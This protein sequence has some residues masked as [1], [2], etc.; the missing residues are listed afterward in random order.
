MAKSKMDANVEPSD[1]LG[2]KSPVTSLILYGAC[3]T[4]ATSPAVPN[5]FRTIPA[6]VPCDPLQHLWIMRWYR[7]CLLEGRSPFFCPEVQ[8]PV[9]APLGNFSPMHLQTLLFVPISALTGSD[10]Y[11]YNLI[12][13][14]GLLSTAMGTYL[15]VWAVLRQTTC[16]FFGG[17]ATMLC[18]PM[19]AHAAT[20][21]TELLYLG[22]FPLAMIAW[23]RF[24]DRPG[25]RRLACAVGAV[26]LM[27]MGAAYYVVMATIPMSLYVIWRARCAGLA[28]LGAWVRD[29]AGWWLGFGALSVALLAILFSAS[30]WASAHGHAMSRSKEE[31]NSYGASPW[32]Y[33]VPTPGHRLG[34]CLPFD[35]ATIEG[36][37]YSPVVGFFAMEKVSYLGAVSLALVAYAALRRVRFPDAGFWWTALGVSV[38]LSLGSKGRVG[39]FEVELP[40][41]WLYDHVPIFRLTR[42]PSRFNLFAAVFAAVV[43]SAGLKDLLGRLP[44]RMAPVVMAVLTVI[45]VADLSVPLGASQLPTLPQGY[46]AILARDPAATFYEISTDGGLEPSD[47]SKCL[48]WQSLHGAPTNECYSG[49]GNSKYQLEVGYNS[50]LRYA[51]MHEADYLTQPD[52][53]CFD[54]ISHAAY[55][56][57]TWLF[58]KANDYRYVVLYLK[59]GFNKRPRQGYARLRELLNASL[60][61]E[62][63]E[64]AIFDRERLR[65]P[66]RPTLVCGKGWR[67][68]Y[69]DR[70]NR[71]TGRDARLALFNPETDREVVFVL[72]ARAFRKV[73][74]VEIRTADATLI[75]WEVRPDAFETFL[76]PPLPLPSGYQELFL[77]CDGED[78]PTRPEEN[79]VGWDDQPY[80]IFVN[81]LGIVAVP[82]EGPSR[83]VPVGLPDASPTR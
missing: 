39:S 42:V 47:P 26:L 82:D 55:L 79:C 34:R 23:S 31:F 51:P 5:F 57:Y 14:I 2:W 30:L 76:S 69:A 48:Y 72:N 63:D 4:V 9:G 33:V 13:L 28:G 80:S 44:R 21:H 56:D 77:V 12:W 15:L 35:P 81:G 18:G 59:D 75:R 78:A 27:A 17:L 11:S 65:R 36:N 22:P 41:S 1:R 60:V 67:I 32:S 6:Y 29:R 66:Q 50:P 38:V 52:D 70:L 37:I 8:H 43:A 45:V 7:S 73:R 74:H 16:A 24:V 46:R 3:L 54:T 49:I 68:G 83:P 40:A 20:G 61:Y 71:V 19:L 64:M 62:D 10:L 58:L 53:L 25:R